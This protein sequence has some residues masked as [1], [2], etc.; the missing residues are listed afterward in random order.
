MIPGI[1]M[2]RINAEVEDDIYLKILKV[3]NE[4]EEKEGKSIVFAEVVR[5]VLKR[6]LEV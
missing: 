6:G 5:I 3:R 4:L 1:Y 2:P